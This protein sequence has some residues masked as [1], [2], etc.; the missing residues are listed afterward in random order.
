MRS[1]DAMARR[2]PPVT[3]PLSQPR[4]AKAPPHPEVERQR[5]LAAA[6]NADLDARIGPPA[7]VVPVPVRPVAMRAASVPRAREPARPAVVPVPRGTREPGNQGTS[8]PVPRVTWGITKP[9]GAQ[10]PKPSSPKASPV[11]FAKTTAPV[12]PV[13]ARC[14]TPECTADAQR[15]RA[16]TAPPLCGYCRRCYFHAWTRERA[17]QRVPRPPCTVPGCTQRA[18]WLHVGTLPAHEGYCRVHRQKARKGCS[19]APRGPCTQP[20]CPRLAGRVLH[21]M[22]RTRP[23]HATWCVPCRLRAQ[24]VATNVQRRAGGVPSDLAARVA[25]LEAT[26]ADLA[27]ALQALA[28]RGAP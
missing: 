2:T 6:F 27:L 10:A 18:G 14:R 22:R 8:A 25:A 1:G 24:Q 9:Q 21:G 16:T 19:L 23:E 20:G 17:A 5:A 12:A 15:A 26:V 11:V 4:G 28:E 3:V 13:R 7:A